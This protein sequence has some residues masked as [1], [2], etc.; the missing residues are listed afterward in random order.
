M[1]GSRWWSKLAHLMMDRGQREQGSKVETPFKVTSP[2][3]YLLQLQF[4]PTVFIIS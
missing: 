3:I 1:V 4:L 2:V